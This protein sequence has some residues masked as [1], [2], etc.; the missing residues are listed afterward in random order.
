MTNTMR[1]TE[2]QLLEFQKRKVDVAKPATSTNPIAPPAQ[3]P[4]RSKYGSTRVVVDGKKFDSKLE[5]RYYQN[6]KLEWYA[7]KVLWFV[8]QVPFELPGGIRYRLDFLVIRPSVRVEGD[9]S[10]TSK[11]LVAIELVDC[12]GVLTPVS[13]NKIRQ[14]EAIYGVTIKIVKSKDVRIT[15]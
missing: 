15:A 9:I 6:L 8:R 4:T 1:W 7:G 5:A 10:V 13:K 12:K 3:E 2:E 14:A 11:D